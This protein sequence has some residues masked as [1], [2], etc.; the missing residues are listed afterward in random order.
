MALGRPEFPPSGHGGKILLQSSLETRKKKRNTI[1]FTRR[2][3]SNS[4]ARFS[5]ISVL[6]VLGNKGFR[7]IRQYL[8]PIPNPG[9]NFRVLYTGFLYSSVGV[10]RA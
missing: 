9:P 1:D 3:N 8:S 5:I 2:G 4:L 7:K 10:F 6:T